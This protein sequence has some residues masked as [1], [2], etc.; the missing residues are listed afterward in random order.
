MRELTYLAIVA[1]AVA[2]IVVMPALGDKP[3]A[4]QAPPA[5]AYLY[6][7]AA[8]AGGQPVPAGYTI[9]AHVLDYSSEP[10]TVRD[11][12]R[13][14]GL[15]VLPPG[16]SY[17]DQSVTFRLGGM[18][19]AE[20]TDEFVASSVPQSE[21]GFDLTFPLL[22]DPTPTP[23]PVPASPTP[24]PIVVLPAVYEGLIVVA[25]GPVP[26]DAR[27]VA[28]IGAYESPPAAVDG[29]TYRSLVVDPNDSTLVGSVIEFY[30]NGYRSRN[31]SSYV[32][33]ARLTVDLVFVGL[34]AATPT[35]TRTPTP[36]ATATPPPTPTR[37]P[38]PTATATPMPTPTRTPTP[39]ATATPTPT[40]THTPTPTATA[41]PTPVEVSTAVPTPAGP[42]TSMQEEESGGRCGAGGALTASA[43]AANL[44]LLGAPL[45]LVAVLKR[46][47]KP[48]STRARRPTA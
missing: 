1:A 42:G 12:G 16:P 31:T 34:P 39:T 27:L 28:R 22:P 40:P 4:A 47:R 43:A 23:T 30:L 17:Y 26:E 29:E 38:T 14:L 20:E 19:M 5:Q 18:V 21:P 2:L 7:G 25:G 35:P 6:S 15:R 48:R 46:S 8:T 36:T 33:G 24:T 41:V 32:S 9:T 44:L 3:A 37:T 11:G 45:G 13:Y 10:V